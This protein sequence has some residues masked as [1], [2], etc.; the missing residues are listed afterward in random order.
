MIVPS[1]P[2]SPLVQCALYP[3]YCYHPTTILFCKLFSQYFGYNGTIFF[4]VYSACRSRIEWTLLAAARRVGNLGGPVYGTGALS[5]ILYEQHMSLNGISLPLELSSRTIGIY[6][7][8]F[9]KRSSI[10][11]I[12]RQICR[13][14]EEHGVYYSLESGVIRGMWREV[15]AC[16]RGRTR[17][18][19]DFNVEA[20]NNEAGPP[21]TGTQLWIHA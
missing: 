14:F 12:D 2:P 19:A 1:P 7:T 8:A 20:K 10:H 17:Y 6:S 3:K 16:S 18:D 5:K 13:N 4:T 11:Q 9:S 21:Q 15:D